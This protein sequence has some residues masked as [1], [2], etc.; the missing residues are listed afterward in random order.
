MSLCHHQSYGKTPQRLFHDSDN[1]SSRL[2][3]SAVRDW[4]LGLHAFRQAE[5]TLT[6]KI[7][8]QGDMI[9]ETGTMTGGGGKPKGGRMC[10]GTA[11]PK[12][13]DTRQAQTDLAEAESEFN[14]SKQVWGPPPLSRHLP[15]PP[16]MPSIFGAGECL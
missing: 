5:E 15:L 7:A 2:V 10:L 9:N 4:I 1:P 16:L 6:P 12:S 11:A 14:V 8:L 13:L 3:I